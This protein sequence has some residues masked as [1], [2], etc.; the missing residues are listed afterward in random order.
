MYIASLFSIL[1][2]ISFLAEAVHCSI[3][4]SNDDNVD[5]YHWLVLILS[6]IGTLLL[7][8]GAVAIHDSKN[9]TAL[10]VYQGKT[11]LEVTYQGNVPVDSAVV[12]K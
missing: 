6:V 4:I 11:I 1:C 10:D 3:I 7:T 12:F 9:P 5:G 2:G 8:L